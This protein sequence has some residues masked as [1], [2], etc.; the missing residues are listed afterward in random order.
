MLKIMAL[1]VSML[2]L[3]DVFAQACSVQTIVTDKGLVSCYS[4]PNM[5][6]YCTGV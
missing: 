5:P 1:I 2:F 4:C 6:P 3:A